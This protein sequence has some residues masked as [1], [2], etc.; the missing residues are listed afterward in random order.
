MDTLPI[1]DKNK[2]A[3]VLYVTTHLGPLAYLFFNNIITYA[4]VETMVRETPQSSL[5]LK[6]EDI[7]P[8]FK[9]F[10]KLAGEYQEL[11][12][13]AINCVISPRCMELMLAHVIRN[14]NVF[15][16]AGCFSGSIPECALKIQ[17]CMQQVL[18]GLKP[19]SEE[20]IQT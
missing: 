1:P 6:K 8:G 20:G 14:L 19:T 16:K 5:T 11:F 2:I 3:K 18:N 13:K 4:D 9:I 7:L 15:E 12:R 17:K 10:S